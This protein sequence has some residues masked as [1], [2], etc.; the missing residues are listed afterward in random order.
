VTSIQGI[1]IAGFVIAAI[2]ASTVFRTKLVYRLMAL[3]LF[4]TATILV[5]FP[6]VT[7]VIAHALG[8]GRGA[9]LVLYV[10]LVTGIDVA[11]LLYLR[12][13]DLEQRISRLVREVALR[14]ARHITA[15]TE[16]ESTEKNR[17]TTRL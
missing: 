14:D 3:L 2:F 1:L 6:D 15:A 9:D 16:P 8:V 5:I 17:V 13:R 10:S 4:L 11:L 12:I 7:T